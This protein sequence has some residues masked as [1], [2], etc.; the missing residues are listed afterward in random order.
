MHRESGDLSLRP[1]P[2]TLTV[3][4]WQADNVCRE[5]AIFWNIVVCSDG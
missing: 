5:C 3:C 4:G 1:H 2:G